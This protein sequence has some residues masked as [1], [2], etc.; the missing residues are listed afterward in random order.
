MAEILHY[1]LSTE[2]GLLGILFDGREVPLSDPVPC[3]DIFKSYPPTKT[4]KKMSDATLGEEL[5]E[6]I[7]SRYN[8]PNVYIQMGNDVFFLQGRK[9][10]GHYVPYNVYVE[11]KSDETRTFPKNSMTEIKFYR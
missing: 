3:L 9:I 10:V 5:I 2:K 7:K 8:R 4:E 1:V 6:R 11:R